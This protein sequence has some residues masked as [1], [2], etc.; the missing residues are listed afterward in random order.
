MEFSRKIAIFIKDRSIS[1]NADLVYRVNPVCRIAYLGNN[2][3][4]NHKKNIQG[5][6]SK[7]Y[8]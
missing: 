8:V 1:E 2:H 3:I 4:N 7:D 5:S 6:T